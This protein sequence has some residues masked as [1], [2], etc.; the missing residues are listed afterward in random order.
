MVRGWDIQYVILSVPSY[1]FS[2][3]SNT[4]ELN[5]APLANAAISLEGVTVT[6]ATRM[7]ASFL[8]FTFTFCLDYGVTTMFHCE[9]RYITSTV[10]VLLSLFA[11]VEVHLVEATGT[12]RGG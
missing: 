12:Q 6:A 9:Y 11:V 4:D 10:I 5:H 1:L 7:K 2:K 3:E 8:K